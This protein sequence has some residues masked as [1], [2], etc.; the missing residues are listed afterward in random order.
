MLALGLALRLTSGS[1]TSRPSPPGGRG[2]SPR[3]SS[4]SSRPRAGP[5]SGS[6]PTPPAGSPTSP[7][8]GLF[9]PR[10]T[11]TTLRARPSG[12][13]K[14]GG[15]ASTSSSPRSCSTSPRPRSL[16]G[17]HAPPARRRERGPGPLEDLERCRGR[18]GDL[19]DGRE[20]A[21]GVE[22]LGLLLAAIA[23]E[24][25]AGPVRR[26]LDGPRQPSGP[27]RSASSGWP[28]PSATPTAGAGPRR[29]RGGDRLPPPGHPPHAYDLALFLAARSPPETAPP[30]ALRYARRQ[31]QSTGRTGSGPSGRCTRG[32]RPSASQASGSCSAAMPV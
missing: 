16:L 6:A 28:P 19:R 26:R 15:A 17:E 18:R 3:R 9:E 21:G 8:G 1:P 11:T 20:L 10:G 12:R 5:S 23:G 31:V 25:V 22:A 7:T 27:V 24:D 13:L 29:H 32:S 4:S 30:P 2:T 14:P